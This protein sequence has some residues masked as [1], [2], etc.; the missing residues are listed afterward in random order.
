MRRCF[1]SKVKMLTLIVVLAAIAFPILVVGWFSARLSPKGQFR[2]G[3]ALAAAGILLPA[4]LYLYNSIAGRGVERQPV[5]ASHRIPLRIWSS[6]PQFIE[7]A[8]SGPK[9]MDL[10]CAVGGPRMP[11]GAC[12]GSSHFADID[13][14]VREGG[15]VVASGNPARDRKDE[16]DP[17]TWMAAQ[18]M[19]ERGK[20][21]RAEKGL[22]P[23]PERPQPQ[24][25]TIFIDTFPAAFG[26]RYTLE[27]TPHFDKRVETRVSVSWGTV[28]GLGYAV[29]FLLGSL[30]GA[31]YLLGGVLIAQAG[32][33][34]A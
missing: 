11:D 18:R 28:R 34:R 4:A 9:G 1:A 14:V 26:H 8:V 20:A 15:R 16:I 5:V 13:W 31:A 25:W 10:A 7:I 33:S 17:V 22:P 12:Y 32:R 21:L 30:C 23:Q 19:G 27:L 29:L 3:L 6:G 2:A 24:W